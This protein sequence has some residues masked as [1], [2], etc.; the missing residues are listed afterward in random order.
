MFWC[1][2]NMASPHQQVNSSSPWT[3]I[4]PHDTCTNRRRQE[5]HR[6][7]SQTG[8]EKALQTHQVLLE[9]SALQS[10]SVQLACGEVCSQVPAEPSL[11]LPQPGNRVE[12]AESSSWCSPVSLKSQAL[13]SLRRHGVETNISTFPAHRPPGAYCVTLL[14]ATL[15]SFHSCSWWSS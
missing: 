15:G 5:W 2:V 13:W 12:S 10:P 9:G 8:S 3:W 7:T 1:H 11:T 6:V 14:L 4:G